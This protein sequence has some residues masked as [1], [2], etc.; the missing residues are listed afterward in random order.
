MNLIPATC[1]LCWQKQLFPI[2]A[3]FHAA[4]H[5]AFFVGEPKWPPFK[6]ELTYAMAP[7]TPADVPSAVAQALFTWGLET[8]FTFSEVQDFNSA[9]LRISFETGD[10][11]DGLAFDGPGGVVAHAFAPTDG[12]FHFDA[13]ENWALGAKKN[14]FDLVT[15]AIHEI[16]HI[17]GLQHSSV[18]EAIMF[19]TIDRGTTKRLNDDDVKGIQEFFLK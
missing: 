14:A 2:S 13:T 4:S 16:G 9:D 15:V 1:I 8:N 5:Y 3:Q 11:G 17:L 6:T 12:R 7:G 19:A 18:E 10:H